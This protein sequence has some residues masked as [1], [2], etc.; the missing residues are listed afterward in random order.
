MARMLTHLTSAGVPVC[1]VLPVLDNDKELWFRSS[2]TARPRGAVLLQDIG[3]FCQQLARWIHDAGQ[4]SRLYRHR[5][6]VAGDSPV[7][8]GP[9]NTLQRAVSI[10]E[11]A[12]KIAERVP[13]VLLG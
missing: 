12:L 2:L 6:G 7:A 8:V 10:V 3:I 13:W 4:C 11:T 1:N 9:S 5:Q